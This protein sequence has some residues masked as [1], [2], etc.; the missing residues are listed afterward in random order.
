MAA[1][2]YSK[3]VNTSPYYAVRLRR[4]AVTALVGLFALVLGI[5]YLL[6]FGNMALIAVKSQDQIAA[7]GD[8]PIW[9]LEPEVYNYEGKDYPIYTVPFED[10]TSRELALVKKGRQTSQFVDPANPD[11]G[12]VDWAGNWRGLAQVSTIA[13]HFDNFGIA[14]DIINFPRLFGNTVAI[15]LIGMVG[16]LLSSIA[17]AY[18]FARFPIPGKNILFLVLIGTIILPRQVTLIPTY[19]FF[20]KIGWT[21]SWL[22]LIVPHFFANA[23]NV[24]LLRQFFMT[25]PRELDE[26]AMIDGAS[27]FTVLYR[28]IIPQSWPAIISVGLFHFIFAWNDYFGPLL[29]LL[30]K[31]DLQPISVGVQIFNFQYGQRPE[32]VQATSL[33]AMILPLVIF[34]FAQKVFMRGVVVTG[35]E[36]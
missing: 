3:S 10:G 8:G 28:V 31:P 32:L 36:K 18:A 7:S 6:P 2:T 1:V 11:A 26:A 4:F 33:M 5:G 17:V 20:A 13:P 21:Q 22:P 15:A 35:V 19:A 25:L 24:F 9:P 23:Y 29:Y 27:P 30:G 12:L 34:F 14:W 16:T